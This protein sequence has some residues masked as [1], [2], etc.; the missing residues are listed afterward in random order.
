M[1]PLG[2]LYKI[3]AAGEAGLRPKLISASRMTIIPKL[4]SLAVYHLPEMMLELVV[5]LLLDSQ[6]RKMS[7]TEWA[8]VM[9][10]ECGCCGCL[11]Y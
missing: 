4:L 10:T 5:Y 9:I 8:L 2:P 6:S 7:I 3:L 1:R 11:V